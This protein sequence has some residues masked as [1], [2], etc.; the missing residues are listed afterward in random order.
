LDASS[1]TVNVP[2]CVPAL[3]GVNTT[4]IVQLAFALSDEPQLLVWL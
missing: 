4:L 3:V 1:V 2:V